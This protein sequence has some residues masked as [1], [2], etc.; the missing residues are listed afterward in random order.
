[1]IESKHQTMKII[2]AT[3]E[4]FEREENRYQG[5]GAEIFARFETDDGFQLTR[6]HIESSGWAAIDSTVSMLA[7]EHIDE[8]MGQHQ[9]VFFNVSG[10]TLAAPI[11]FALWLSRIKELAA[12]YPGR[13]GVEIAQQNAIHTNIIIQKRINLLKSA[14]ILMTLDNADLSDGPSKTLRSIEWDFCKFNMRQITTRSQAQI[15]NSLSYCRAAGIELIAERV[16]SPHLVEVCNKNK[17]Q[18]LQGFH[19]GR[20]KPMINF[21]ANV[22]E[23]RS[24]T[25]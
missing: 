6:T 18:F 25:S 4:I 1:M 2:L 19:L 12:A 9:T 10:D 15:N 23:S 17:I 5:A 13:I 11:A 16:E 8:I 7:C 24:T 20:P 21:K 22:T 3:Q 14:S